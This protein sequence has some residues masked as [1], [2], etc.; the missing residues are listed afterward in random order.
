M[1]LRLRLDTPNESMTSERELLKAR[2]LVAQ[3]DLAKK[4]SR[5]STAA[6]KA[7]NPSKSK[8]NKKPGVESGDNKKRREVSVACVRSIA[9]FW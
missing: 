6:P 4:K 5:G 3:A 9:C 1:T 2:L 8:E 7:A